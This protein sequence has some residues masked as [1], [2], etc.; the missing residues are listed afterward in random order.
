MTSRI[1]SKRPDCEE[2][3]MKRDLW[4]TSEEEIELNNDLKYFID[5]KESES[6]IYSMLKFIRL[7]DSKI[8]KNSFYSKNF[9]EIKE[10]G[11]GSFGSV[12]KVKI[13]EDSDNYK[14]YRRKGI[15]YSAI[16]RIES[17]SVDKNEII[18]LY[19]NYKIITKDYSENEYLVKHFDA[20]FE[21][22]VVSNQS[23]ISLYIEM[24]LYDKTLD[25]VIKELTNDSILKTTE[26]LTTIGYY[27]ASQIFIQ[28]L[29]GVNYLHKQNPPLIHR[30]LK[31]ANILFKKCDQKKFCVKI[32][33]F[34]LIATHDF[35]EKSHSF[36]TISRNFRTKS[37]RKSCSDDS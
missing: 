15:E 10:L 19:L 33:D 23:G 28:I 30:D 6:T 7:K 14:Y 26:S 8:V 36:V 24:E 9:E 29:E 4:A 16:K 37:S 18:R 35:P 12:F 22:I 20:W 32:A 13:K 5:S 17:T 21:E 31:P 34:G 11:F 25:D 27:I 3:L 2:I 1:P